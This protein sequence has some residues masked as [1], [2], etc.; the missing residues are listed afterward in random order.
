MAVAG[1]VV[2]GGFDDGGDAGADAFD[3]EGGRADAVAGGVVV[4]D[5]ER[6]ATGGRGARAGDVPD[7]WAAID[8]DADADADAGADAEAD[9]D[10]DAGT[11]DGAVSGAEAIVSGRDA[12]EASPEAAGTRVE[13]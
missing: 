10:T 5:A 13:A 2:D 8:G 6:A 7:A 1:G 4:A 11:G 12:T 3:V 9:A